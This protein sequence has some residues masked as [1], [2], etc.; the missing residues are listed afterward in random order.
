MIYGIGPTIMEYWATFEVFAFVQAVNQL[1]VAENSADLLV[2]LALTLPRK[3]WEVFQA[4]V[5][6]HMSTDGRDILTGSNVFI[7]FRGTDN[8]KVKIRHGSSFSMRLS[9]QNVPQDRGAFFDR[10]SQ[11][12]FGLASTTVAEALR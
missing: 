10:F 4:R 6:H 12:G 5:Q 11:S 9:G 2:Q 1:A 3:A 8:L 7:Q